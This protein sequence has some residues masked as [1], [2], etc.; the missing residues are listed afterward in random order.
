[1][2]G[3]RAWKLILSYDGEINR[4]ASSHTYEKGPQLFDLIADPHEKKNL[5]E[6]NPAEVGP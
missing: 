1:M 3:T 6:D 4:H 5:A 2:K